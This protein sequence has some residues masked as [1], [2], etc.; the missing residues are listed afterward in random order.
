MQK[1]SAGK[2]KRG[3]KALE[4]I[5]QDVLGGLSE[6]A[7]MKSFETPANTFEIL[8][9]EPPSEPADRVESAAKP[10]RE[11]NRAY[12]SSEEAE[13]IVMMENYRLRKAV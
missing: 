6:L 2:P 8:A 9:I 11:A 3:S 13:G 1:N 7:I 10:R 5:M 4:I 12:R